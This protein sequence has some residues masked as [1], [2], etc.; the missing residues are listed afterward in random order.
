MTLIARPKK[1]RK[2][3]HFPKTLAF[4]PVGEQSTKEAIVLTIDEYEALRLIDKEGQSQEDCS[5]SM[6]VARTTVQM[7]YASARKKLAEAITEG[8]PIEIEGGD[9]DLC[10]GEEGYCSKTDCHK[11]LLYNQ[12]IKEEGITRIALVV[13]GEEIATDMEEAKELRL[14]D[15]REG[16]LIASASID[17][18]G[19]K[20]DSFVDYLHILH[21]DELICDEIGEY[22]KE[23]LEE[24]GIRLKNHTKGN[25]EEII[26]S[27]GS[28]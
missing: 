28:N 13:N 27:Y 3:C 17:N 12:Y 6:K 1:Y 19:S 22:S 24:I 14:V 10:N 4:K 15:F 26:R 21:V 25:L 16:K 5:I 8:R 18:L 23:G 9:Y 2:I 20:Q 11:K 7:I